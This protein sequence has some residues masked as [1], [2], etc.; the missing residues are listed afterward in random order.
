MP[1]T[2]RE[3]KGLFVL[4]SLAN[5]VPV[6]LPEHGAFPELI[7]E[8]GGGLLVAPEDSGA[9]AVGLQTLLE[10]PRLR[11]ELGRRGR[12]AVERKYTDDLS[13]ERT[14]NLY[15]RCVENGPAR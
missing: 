3:P 4:E 12:E 10:D 7:R 9:L 15:R 8:T 5:R 14:L 11:A 13:A 1:T 2:Y 6:V